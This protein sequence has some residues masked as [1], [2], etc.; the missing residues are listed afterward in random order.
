MK[1]ILNLSKA[2][3]INEEDTPLIL[4]PCWTRPGIL[5]VGLRIILWASEVAGTVQSTTAL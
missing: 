1:M 4:G 2:R 3:D 5:L